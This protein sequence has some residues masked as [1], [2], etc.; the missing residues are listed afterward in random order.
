MGDSSAPI[1]SFASDDGVPPGREQAASPDRH[2]R[3]R[4]Q[5]HVSIMLAHIRDELQ[6]MN[7]QGPDVRTSSLTDNKDSTINTGGNQREQVL[8]EAATQGLKSVD[9][10]LNRPRSIAATSSGDERELEETRRAE[11]QANEAAFGATAAAFAYGAAA[12]HYELLA[13]KHNKLA[14]HYKEVAAAYSA[15]APEHNEAGVTHT[16]SPAEGTPVPDKDEIKA[17]KRAAQ[18]AQWKAKIA[19]YQDLEAEYEAMMTDR[20][21]EASRYEALDATG[22]AWI[23]K[24]EASIDDGEEMTAA[25]RRRVDRESK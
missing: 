7:E 10:V 9:E 1:H 17:A 13:R 6:R 25:K 3:G 14:A 11:H 24:R 8:A 5:N 4:V 21:A 16:V 18:V 19:V 23:A 20:E 2:H 12:V 15:G 22:S